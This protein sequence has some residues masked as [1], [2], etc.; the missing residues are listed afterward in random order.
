MAPFSVEHIIPRKRGGPTEQDNLALSCSGCNGHK[1]DKIEGFDS[2]RQDWAPLY[3]PRLDVWRDHFVWDEHFERL[4]GLTPTGQATIETLHLNR[5][6]VVNL[7]RILLSMGLHP[8]A[9]EPER[10]IE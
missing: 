8:L 3:N 6:G 2:I 9:D 10:A 5:E 4:I 1:Y 7:R